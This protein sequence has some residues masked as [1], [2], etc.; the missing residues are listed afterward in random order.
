ML[1]QCRT[2]SVAAGLIEKASDDD[3]YRLA[4]AM[5]YA[6]TTH[7]TIELPDGVFWPD[8]QSRL[9]YKRYFFDGLWNGVLNRCNRVSGVTSGILDPGVRLNGAAILG[10]P[11]SEYRFGESTWL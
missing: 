10:A 5:P 3:L 8:L 4:E 2:S 7:N 6:T 1:F 9:L 11:G